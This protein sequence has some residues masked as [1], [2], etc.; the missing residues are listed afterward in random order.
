MKENYAMNL[1]NK[2]TY[3]PQKTFSGG[4]NTEIIDEYISNGK[5]YPLKLLCKAPRY[6]ECHIPNCNQLVCASITNRAKTSV[7]TSGK[8]ELEKCSCRNFCK[9][10]EC[11][12]G[13]KLLKNT[14]SETDNYTK[15]NCR[16]TNIPLR[17][18]CN[19][20]VKC[21]SQY[22]CYTTDGELIDENTVDENKEGKCRVSKPGDRCKDSK[23]CSNDSYC[24]NNICT[25]GK[26][27]DYC[28]ISNNQKCTDNNYCID[29][30]CTNMCNN[31]ND[32]TTN[33]DASYQCINK[34]CFVFDQNL[35][36]SCTGVGE[37]CKNGYI[38]NRNNECEKC[39]D[40]LCSVNNG[41][42]TDNR[43]VQNLSININQQCDK[44]STCLNG[45]CLCTKFSI[46]KS[47][48]KKQCII[49]N[50]KKKVDLNNECVS[51]SI[52]NEGKCMNDKNG[53]LIID[54]HLDT[55]PDIFNICKN[56]NYLNKYCDLKSQKKITCNENGNYICKNNICAKC[57]YD[58][59][60]TTNYKNAFKICNKEKGCVECNTSSDCPS[61][62][63]ECNNGKCNIKDNSYI[64]SSPI[65]T[66]NSNDKPQRHSTPLKTN[67]SISKISYIFKIIG[68]VFVVLIII[69]ILLKL[70]KQ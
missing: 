39:T 40:P 46:N 64:H 11:Y 16:K 26:I 48:Q 65:K 6:T 62:R 28:N 52:C 27:G 49:R 42:C 70:K 7:P 10:G 57:E 63:Y 1:E 55:G 8:S 4:I 38:C 47:T 41:T 60:C 37:I 14:L 3:C 53:T 21:K 67:N 68:I 29:N 44:S 23:D 13:T 59:D 30:K 9:N 32:C 58:T 50:C 18:E 5:I 31:N 19:K 22:N 20:N 56:R 33:F 17:Y 51:N 66:S 2:N 15:T 24:Y 61:S 54:Q 12:N 43:C 69:L 36:E 35:P 25:A 34:K 45:N